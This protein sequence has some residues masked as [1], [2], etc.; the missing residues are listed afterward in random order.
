MSSQENCISWRDVEM[1][2]EWGIIFFW[3]KSRSLIEGLSKTSQSAK[4]LGIHASKR[5]SSD[6]IISI[7]LGVPFIVIFLCPFSILLN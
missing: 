2:A 4:E 6:F 5:K 1:V 7:L 3:L